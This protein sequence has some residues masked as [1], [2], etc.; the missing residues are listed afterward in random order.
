MAI[1]LDFHSKL[2]LIRSIQC[3]FVRFQIRAIAQI[4]LLIMHR[5]RERDVEFI[6]MEQLRLKQL[7]NQK[8][9]EQKKTEINQKL[10]ILSA[11]DVKTD[12][13]PH[14]EL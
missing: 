2:H 12:Q 14:T 1:K 8:I 6:E 13:K 3:S 10:N 9:A 11:F 7:L 5:I 4:Y